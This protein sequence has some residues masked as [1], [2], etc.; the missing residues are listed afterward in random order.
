MKINYPDWDDNKKI[1]YSLLAMVPLGLGEVIG[2]FIHGYVSDKWGQ[3]SGVL[4]LMIV[5]AVAYGVAFA[6]IASWSFSVLTFFVT[7]IWGI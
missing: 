1:E 3:K 2:G 7:F 5:T 6:Y 4:Y